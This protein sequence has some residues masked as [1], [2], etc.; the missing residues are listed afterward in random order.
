MNSIECYSG[1]CERRRGR[2]EMV[3]PLVLGTKRS[4]G[5]AGSPMF[6]VMLYD[7]R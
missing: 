2:H 1:R 3:W 5:S 7:S 4:F 6:D